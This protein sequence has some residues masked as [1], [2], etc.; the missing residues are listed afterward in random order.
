VS[1]TGT[2]LVGRDVMAL[3][4]QLAMPRCWKIAVSPKRVSI[5]IVLQTAYGASM[6]LCVANR[7]SVQPRPQPKPTHTDF[8]LQ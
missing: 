5:Y 3:A 1:E 2:T 4:E 7:A 8:D 6:K